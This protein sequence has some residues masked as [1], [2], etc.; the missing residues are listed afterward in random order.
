VG[1]KR[2]PKLYDLRW[3]DEPGLEV[4][5]RPAPIGHVLDLMT[6]SKKIG[7]DDPAAVRDLL[8]RLASCLHS[9]NLEDDDGPVPATYEGLTGQDMD[10]V[11]KILTGWVRAQATVD[12][13][14]PGSSANGQ[15]SAPVPSVPMEPLSPRPP[16]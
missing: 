11:M 15:S 4:A 3:A 6:L 13:P 10:L 8:Q 12:T 9:W 5:V 2:P 14:L 16:S 1:Y 7:D